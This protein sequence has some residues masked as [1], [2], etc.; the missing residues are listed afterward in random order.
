MEITRRNLLALSGT[1]VAGVA[2]AGVANT[3][4]LANESAPTINCSGIV[5][6]PED[7][8]EVYST[9]I[10]V[11]GGGFAGLAASVQAIQN[12][13]DAI[14][15]EAQAVLG[16]NGQGVE[17]TF[18]VGSRFQE[19]QGI[20]IEP[21]EVIRE[22]LN[23]TQWVADGMLYRDLIDNA[24]KNI[25]WLVDECGCV[26]EG[27]IDNYPCGTGEG[28]V[29]SFHWWKDGVA[30]RGY[31]LPMEKYLRDREADIRLNTR[32]LEFSYDEQGIVDGVYAQDMFGDIVKYA[33]KQVIIATGGFA[34]DDRR[35]KRAGFDMGTLDRIGMPGH[36]GDG[37]NMAAA[38]GAKEF[39]GVCY[40]KYNCI[41]RQVDTFGPFW[42]AYAFG[43][44]FLWLNTKCE[45]FVDESI[46]YYVG[47]ITSQTIPIHT[48]GGTCY[49]I[50]DAKTNAEVLADNAQAAAEFDG[51]RDL[52]AELAAIIESGDDIWVADTLEE[53]CAQAGLDYALV[54]GQVDEY[55]GYC[56]AGHD[57]MFGKDAQYL[58][59][60]AEPPFYIALIHERMEGPLGGI[61]T[62]RNF[63]P[64]MENGSILPNVYVTGLDG[65]MLYRDVYP[66]DVPGSASAE[67]IFSGR[68][69]AD[70]A[71]A[72]VADEAARQAVID[73]FMAAREAV[74]E[75]AAEADPTA[76][77]NCHADGR[78]G[79]NPHGYE[80]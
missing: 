62:N 36:Y 21:W 23:K 6:T 11:V 31:V 68:S 66:M 47:N 20:D 64:V 69:A 8:Y 60:I 19:E 41:S 18:A 26:L 63:Q 78:E 43:G 1:A 79:K 50:W 52:E 35:I 29:D 12:G 14:L 9:D 17:G 5:V 59:S 56:A 45:R 25:E 42:G 70:Q 4:A 51:G 48:Q 40:L 53:A 37:V 61:V 30:N 39:P 73:E 75:A 32:A 34:N 10:L 27:K 15:L 54:Q 7:V 76:C 3:A 49:S 55:N 13:D 77:A 2:L 44:P 58:K 65:I 22:E 72:L 46:S 74:D 33:A 67:C 28:K 38:A 24:A 71:H 16:G 80:Y 57:M